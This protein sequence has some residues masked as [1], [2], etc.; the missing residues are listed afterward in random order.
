MKM[1]KSYSKS[2]KASRQPRKQRLYLYN[3]PEHIQG[4]SMKST[5][6]KTLRKRL[7]KR[8]LRVRK[9]DKVKILRGM[10]KGKEGKVDRVIVR[11]R[12]VIVDKAEIYKKDGSKT[13]YPI[14]PSNLIIT[15]LYADDKKRLKR[16]NKEKTAGDTK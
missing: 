3:A 7:G 1:K 10:F 14:D 12:K 16:Q 6:S 2:W 5:L 8:S 4:K 9:N 11:D 13:F 15:E